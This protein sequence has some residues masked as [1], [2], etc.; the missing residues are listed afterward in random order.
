LARLQTLQFYSTMAAQDSL[1]SPITAAADSS[2]LTITL[3][4]KGCGLPQVLQLALD[5]CDCLPP[6]AWPRAVWLKYCSLNYLIVSHKIP[7]AN[8]SNLSSKTALVYLIAIINNGTVSKELPKFQTFGR[9]SVALM[10]LQSKPCSTA[11]PA[12]SCHF[13]WPSPASCHLLYRP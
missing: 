7:V 2:E 13:K 8:L 1:L 9:C 5:D 11:S 12:P 6:S 10:P 3:V 4:S